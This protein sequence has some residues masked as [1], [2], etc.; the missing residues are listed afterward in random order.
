ME[1]IYERVAGIDVG[2]KEVAVTVR[3]PGHGRGAGRAQVTRKFKTFY[4]VLVVMAAWLREQQV[5]HVVMESTG[6]YWRPVFHALCE[7]DAGFEVLL[8][9][10]AHVK[11]VPGRKTDVKDSQWLAQLLE[12]GLLR[13]SFIPPKDI[14]AIRD[15]TRYRKKVVQARTSELQR[16]S[17]VLE[18]AGVKID[19]VMS[20]ITTKSARAMVEAL[21]GG[22]RD[23]RVLADLALGRLR[24][25]IPDLSMAL[26]GRFGDHHAVLARLHLD[27]LDHLDG[28]IARLDAQLETMTLPFCPQIQALCT[29]PGIGE[30]IAQVI[31]SEIGV[32]MSRFPTAGHLAS[33]AGL[34]PGN[35]ESAGKH[36]NTRT[37]PGN[38]EVRTALVE[39]AWCAARTST[40]LGAR[41]RR[42]HRRFG[43][44]GGGKAA[45][46]IAH[47]L[48]VIAWHV[49][50]DGVEFHD[51]GADYFTRPDSPAHSRRKDHLVRELQA[52]GYTVQVTPAA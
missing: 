43:K 31:V 23:P 36:G 41:F 25:K 44:K 8:V 22:E 42:L 48:I 49:L 14:A 30:R 16:L 11:N 24:S 47:D 52:L 21:I 3:S 9:N 35:N 46:A 2:K 5:T 37:R 18:D 51:L 29:I 38:P 39:A 45:V 20:T 17:K 34:C 6:I 15:V 50:R 4:P 40:Y 7:K 10:A 13:G 33:W 12:V 26:A 27:H 19:S 28:M 32:D 1:I